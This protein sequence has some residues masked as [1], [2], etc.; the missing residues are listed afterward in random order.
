MSKS[1]FLS[2]LRYPGGKNKMA[3][4]IR[5][6]IL[7][8]NLNESTYI[9]P[10]AGGA[11]VALYLL[12]NKNCKRIIIN[13]YDRGI[14]AF[15]YSVVHYTEELCQLIRRAPVNIEEWRR[16]REI[17]LSENQDIELLQLGFS[18]FY[19][20]R[21]NV[22][23]IIKAGPI[24]GYEQRSKYKIDCRFNR[25]DL[26]NR[27]Q[28]ISKYKSKIKIYNMDAEEFISKIISKQK[29]ESFIFFDP[30]YFEKGKELY[31][32]FYK[33]DNH[34]NLYKKI[35]RI[36]KHKWIVTYDIVDEIKEIYHS[37]DSKE[38]HISYSAA[39]TG[40]TSETMYTS[41]NLNLPISLNKIIVD[42][43]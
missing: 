37:I 34:A 26:I 30:P 38:Y 24:G 14:Y 21:T 27:I 35:N 12:M 25:D 4:F 40:K 6:I 5:D 41:S 23:G 33:Y 32:N 8:N 28:K 17:V 39:N 11:G 13:D 9:E 10:F 20:N 22:S 3:K 42:K 29:N 43:V 31:N 15:W 16:H 36:K 18:T 19:L 1:R 2:P 7:E